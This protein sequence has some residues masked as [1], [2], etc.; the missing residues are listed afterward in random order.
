MNNMRSLLVVVI[1]PA[2]VEVLC[3]L[4]HLLDVIPL[5]LHDATL[6][7]PICD[8]VRIS[9][10]LRRLHSARVC[11]TNEDAF[12]VLSGAEIVYLCEE[13][14]EQCVLSNKLAGG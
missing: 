4:H 7:E 14:L 1:L 13:P 6:V 11:D 3:I 5:F 2:T 12:T 9:E 10:V 8:P